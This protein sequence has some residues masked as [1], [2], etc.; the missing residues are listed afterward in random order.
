M[1]NKLLT[2]FIATFLFNCNVYSQNLDIHVKYYDPFTKTQLMEKYYTISGS[3]KVQGEYKNWASNGKLTTLTNY[4]NGIYNGLSKTFNK[5]SGKLESEILYKNGKIITE[6]YYLKDIYILVERDKGFTVYE[7]GVITESLKLK[8]GT[9]YKYTSAEEGELSWGANEYEI[10][11]SAE[12][13]NDIAS[14][15]ILNYPNGKLGT[16]NLFREDGFSYLF[17][18][19]DEKG[20]ITQKRVL[21]DEK[22]M[23]YKI[24]YFENGNLTES[25][26]YTYSE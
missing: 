10:K 17:V 4:S 16:Q 1:K 14:E 24:D 12:I 7:N 8:K 5:Y 25:E 22:I 13:R 18:S 21:I 19:Y 2:I 11:N 26:F 23:K 15:I 6:K 20:N 9:E 3:N